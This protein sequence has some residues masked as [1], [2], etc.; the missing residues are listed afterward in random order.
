M[1][2]FGKNLESE[3]GGSKSSILS[4]F[5]DRKP[6]ELVRLASELS[7]DAKNFFELSLQS[8]LGQMPDAIADVHITTSKQSLNQLLL[9]AMITGYLTKIVEDKVSLEKLYNYTPTEMNTLIDQLIKPRV[10]PDNDIDSVL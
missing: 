4:F 5:N 9:S 2:F 7:P 8:L 1:V 6:E 3:L 10:S